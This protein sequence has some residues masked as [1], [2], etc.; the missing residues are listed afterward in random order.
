MLGVQAL[1]Y[2]PALQEQR[3][4]FAAML[5]AHPSG[6]RVLVSGESVVGYA[7]WFPAAREHCPHPLD[8]APGSEAA[9]DCLYL[10]DVSVAPQARGQCLSGVVL[11]E[12]IAAAAAHK[13]QWLALTAV[14]GKAQFW[15]AKGFFPVKSDTHR[16]AAAGYPPDAVAMQALLWTAQRVHSGEGRE[17]WRC[18]SK[19]NFAGKEANPARALLGARVV[20]LDTKTDAVWLQYE[21]LHEFCHSSPPTVQGGLV[22]AFGDMAMAQLLLLG[23]MVRNQRVNVPT[24]ELSVSYLQATRPGTVN[25]VAWSLRRGNSVAFVEAEVR[26]SAH[27]VPWPLQESARERRG[28]LAKL[29]STVRILD[30]G[31]SNSRAKPGTGSKL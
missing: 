22:A 12:L 20:A 30:L 28:L 10:H 27:P 19:L 17:E 21:A 6:A 15:G 11:G 5:A 13:L 3:S 16:L 29:S 26:D 23:G 25:A 24:L 1:C 8:A 14:G 31:K 4:T 2:P 9:H 7:F 18:A